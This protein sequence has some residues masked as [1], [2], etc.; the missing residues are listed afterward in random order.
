[1][2]R[3]R[4]AKAAPI[5]S[6]WTL[7]IEG[8]V[9]PLTPKLDALIGIERATGKTIYQHLDAAHRRAVMLEDLAFIVRFLV[10]ED[11]PIEGLRSPISRSGLHGPLAQLH[12]EQAEAIIVRAGMIDVLAI[13]MVPILAAVK[14]QVDEHGRLM[15]D[16]LEA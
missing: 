4:A 5:D 9:V 10:G 16:K 12:G 13:V 3:K 15:L 8:Q 7:E 6:P 1:M 14:G 11:C 2:T